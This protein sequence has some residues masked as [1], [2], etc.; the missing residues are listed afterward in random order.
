M[1]TKSVLLVAALLAI[2]T[3]CVVLCGCTGG[4]YTEETVDKPYSGAALNAQNLSVERYTNGELY[5]VYK[6]TDDACPVTEPSYDEEGDKNRDSART[7]WE[8][9]ANQY[10][11]PMVVE[12]NG[13]KLESEVTFNN[14]YRVL[15]FEK[16]EK[17]ESGAYRYVN[18]NEDGVNTTL[19]KEK[20]ISVKCYFNDRWEVENESANKKIIYHYA[21]SAEVDY[22]IALYP[23]QEQLDL[24]S[25]NGVTI[26]Y[27]LNQTHGPINYESGN[28]DD[29]EILE[30][31]S[32][33]E[34]LE[35]TD[36]LPQMNLILE[37]DFTIRD[38]QW[39][40]WVYY[41]VSY[42]R[43]SNTSYRVYYK[44]KRVEEDDNLF[45]TDAI[46][47][48]ALDEDDPAA[49]GHFVPLYVTQKTGDGEN[50]FVNAK[51]EF[52]LSTED[53]PY[54]RQ[55]YAL[56]GYSDYSAESFRAALNAL[57]EDTRVDLYFRVKGSEVEGYGTL[58]GKYVTHFVT[59]PI[60]S[61]WG[62]D[63]TYQG[64]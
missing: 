4:D 48:Y 23:T 62:V 14:T 43:L 53:N 59:T 30:A 11:T 21:K 33:E 51:L 24:S 10:T 44:W 42:I 1:K 47:Y 17:T 20:N 6:F 29:E 22:D 54:Y 32:F 35:L 50:D 63:G 5:V 9:W 57:P 52:K 49:Y 13:V 38:T 8:E 19:T 37:R 58:P 40:L 28:Y 46:D 61:Q 60:Q 7:A 3:L 34:F 25:E 64:N 12:Y 41:P 31:E 56:E 55:F 18:L 2:A 39:A 27:L 45:R 16:C 36:L 26:N 15:I